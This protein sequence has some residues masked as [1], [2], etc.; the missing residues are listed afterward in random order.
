MAV[1]KYKDSTGKIRDLTVIKGD[2]GP[3]GPR[4]YSGRKGDKG[5][6]GGTLIKGSRPTLKDLINDQPGL[7]VQIGDGYLIEEDSKLYIWDGEKWF[8]A[9]DFIPVKLDDLTDVKFDNEILDNTTVL[10][11]DVIEKCWKNKRLE[12]EEGLLTTNE[13]IIVSIENGIG[14]Y[15]END[16]IP[17]GTSFNDFVKKLTHKPKLPSYVNPELNIK[18]NIKTANYGD[19]ISPVITLDYKQNNAGKFKICRIYKNDLLLEVIGVFQKVISLENINVT[20]NINIKVEIEYFEGE[21]LTDS[22]GNLSPEGSIKSGSIMSELTILSENIC[23][24]YT[25]DKTT[26]PTS[27]D[28]KTLGKKIYNVSKNQSLSIDSDLNSK[29]I[30]F[31]YPKDLGDCKEINYVDFDKHNKDVFNR[32]EVSI[33]I[34]ETNSLIYYVFYFIAPIEIGNA[35]FV[36]TI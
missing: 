27:T 34:S 24:V 5:D 7:S 13:E 15:K 23:Y 33:K 16:V 32:K 21:I 19:T 22:D 30:V 1:I 9:S 18:C 10:M 11:Y 35:T 17:V 8:S 6:K 20:E 12:V 3:V 28:I 14:G 31:A 4:G 25:T 2:R 36:L 29:T 26:E